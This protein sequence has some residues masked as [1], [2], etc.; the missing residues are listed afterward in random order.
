MAK[1]V[2]ISFAIGATLAGSFN[3]TFSKASQALSNLSKYT[4]SLQKTSGQIGSYQKMQSAM[5]QTSEKL[6][7]ARAKVRELGAQM[8]ST[9]TPTE[10]MKRQFTAANIEANRLQESLGNQ[11]RK[12]GELRT[13]LTG[14]GVDTKNLT[15]EQ[16]RL[17]A[18]SQKV[19][20]AQDRLTKSR[21]RLAQ[22]RQNLSWSNIKGEFM[23]AAGLGYSLYKPVSEAANFEQA[24]ARVNAVAFSGGGRDKTADAEAFKALQEQA[25]QLGRDTQFTAVQAAQSQENLARAGFKSNE[26]ISAMPG[27]LNM[28]AAEG[29]DLAQA[30]DIAASTLRGFNLNADQSNRIADVLAQTSAASNTS[31]A[32]LGA[33]MKYVAPIAAGLGVSLEE[34]AAMLGVM[35]N[36]GIKDTQAGTALRAALLRLSK[37]P[38]AVAKALGELG[39]KS[40]D[41]N[42]RLREMPE[43]MQALSKRLKDMGEADQMKY[44]ANIF[45][46]EASAGMLAVMK[47]ATNGTL[48][49]L[50]YLDVESN[51]IMTAIIEH[52]NKGSKEAVVSLEEMR[53]GM[54]ES[55]NYARKLGISYKDLS[56]AL[57]LLARSGIKGE[58]AD[59]GLTV[60][61]KQLA[62]QPK[63]VQA[64][65]KQFNV[66][67]YTDDGHMK[68]FPVLMKEIQKSVMGITDQ[69]KRLNIIESIF[70]K[71]SG[72]TIQALLKTMTD[73]TLSA[74]NEV[75]EKATGVSQEMADKVN[76]TMRG[77]W[78]K[79]GSAM[80]DLMITVGDVLLPSVTS[81]VDSFTKLTSWIGKLAHE[82]P[83]WTKAIVGTVGAFAA[84]KVAMFGVKIGWNLMRLP[85]DMAKV[86][87]DTFHVKSLVAAKDVAENT[88]K[89]GL[90]SRVGKGISNGF[91]GIGKAFSALGKGVGSLFKKLGNILA[92][93]GKAIWNFSKAALYHTREFMATAATK[94][95]TAAQWL[96]NAAMNA[97]RKF[98]DVA[99]L[100]L[101]HSKQLLITAATKAWTAVQWLWNLAMKAGSELLDI[102]KLILYHSKQLLI[103]GA[104]KA[105][106]AA[107][108]LWNAAMNANPVG[109]LIT[110]IAGLIA[111]G[112]LLYK[113]WDK[114]KAFGMKMWGWI[115]EKAQAFGEWWN[116][117]TLADIFAKI[118][119]YAEEIINKIKGLWQTFKDWLVSLFDF[120][121]FGS[122]KAPTPEQK[123][124]QEAAAK[125]YVQQGPSSWQSDKW[126]EAYGAKKHAL[127]G[128]F[129][130]PHL[131]LVAEA[132]R[133]AIIPLQNKQ[134]GLPLLKQAA[135]ELGVKLPELPKIKM[136]NFELPKLPDFSSLKSAI[137]EPEIKMP[138]WKAADKERN[139]LAPVSTTNNNSENN[140]RVINFSPNVSISIN[141]NGQGSE[142]NI[143]EAVLNVLAEYKNDL[144]R[145]A[146]V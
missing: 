51:G 118:P 122:F 26:I 69:T 140:S 39:I 13:A 46:T 70:G 100:I 60:A 106:T 38:K 22:T 109:L 75:A 142:V 12:L 57:A 17:A 37:E 10:V 104:T 82:N 124:Q 68:E 27:L 40:R 136:P 83:A 71:G 6:N 117:W 20:E 111:I 14:A 34:T 95:W 86:A 138:L 130:T 33:S 80:S 134:R 85:F 121:L 63:K 23:T 16:A 126:A 65:L 129:S 101:Y 135:Q 123:A 133:E 18:Q 52:V 110:A 30:A 92:M 21:M 32:G 62:E 1:M 77:A 28:A 102:G 145:L 15:S 98:L 125:V 5:S 97:G 64:A 139:I 93:S 144:E 7:A 89:A 2:E 19:T 29:M 24:M 78:T 4:N 84:L 56:I 3:G 120:N 88:K 107:Q 31:I 73:E 116:S 113:N 94:A 67:A 53:A 99:K 35:G 131:G 25:R 11:R 44:L 42:G 105:W 45:G 146:F 76:K 91:K 72:A 115:K 47:G 114:I 50:R 36:A 41:A 8:R 87:M 96:W 103:A 49:Q 81:L 128:I 59:K 74:Y 55:G 137:I 141:G 112:Y 108:W 119:E 66:S 79:A 90:F 127:G 58:Q 48:Q 132:G 54:D 43:L 61:F 9:A 143:R